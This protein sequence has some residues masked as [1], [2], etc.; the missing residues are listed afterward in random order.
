MGEL[1]VAFFGANGHQPTGLVA[2]AQRVKVVGMA[3][4]PEETLAKCREQMPDAYSEAKPYE[5][6][7]TILG[8]TG[9][10][11][12]FFEMS[13]G[14]FEC[15]PGFFSNM[16]F[17][18]A[19]F[20]ENLEDPSAYIGYLGGDDCRMIEPAFEWI[21]AGARPF[22]LLMITSVAICAVKKY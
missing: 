5:S 11:T 6:L 19:W 17:D 1:R 21:K 20:R 14:N 10:R 9:Y 13:K 2:Q 7:A 3:D 12:A 15:A 22:F 18:W 4:M 8:R 16:G